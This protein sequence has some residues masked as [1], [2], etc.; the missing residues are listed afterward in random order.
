VCEVA[1]SVPAG[2][3]GPI[4]GGGVVP[5]AARPVQW[6]A[7]E[8][9]PAPRRTPEAPPGPSPDAVLAAARREAERLLQEARAQAEALRAQ[10]EAEA[11][12]LR[13]R[14]KA[15]G[16]RAGRAEALAAARALRAQAQRI[17]RRALRERR[18]VLEALAGDVA[19]LALDVARQ[20]LAREIEQSPDD[21]LR[22]LRQLLPRVDGPVAVRVHPGLAPIVEAE[23]ASLG[24]AVAVRPDPAVAEGGL[25][26]ET[27][28]GYLD[29]TVEGRL[30]RVA[31]AL[32][33]VSR[34]RG[35]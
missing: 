30:Q 18:A 32:G 31:S 6:L 16:W 35:A 29:A 1:E 28:E 5:G 23:A 27:E 22:L 4:R 34:E 7:L 17:R 9:P 33:G 13:A 15:E 3:G 2:R 26:L 25:V 8:P 10:A 24:R 14:A 12:A 21:I 20:V 19:R 11:E